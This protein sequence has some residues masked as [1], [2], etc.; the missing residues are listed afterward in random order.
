METYNFKH[1]AKWDAGK[2]YEVT[3]LVEADWGIPAMENKVTTIPF[4]FDLFS[5][6]PVKNSHGI[7]ITYPTAR[8]SLGSMR[9]QY[10]NKN[11]IMN[12][13]PI[14][15]DITA[16]HD[17]ILG[18]ILSARLVNGPEEAEVFIEKPAVCQVLAAIWVLS[19]HG[20]Q[21]VN[22]LRKAI[23]VGEKGEI[24]A[25]YEIMFNERG[26]IWRNK[27]YQHGYSTTDEDI[28]TLE[29]LNECVGYRSDGT[30]YVAH[31]YEGEYP[32]LL[33]GGADGFVLFH[34]A[35]IVDDGHEPADETTK[36][37]FSLLALQRATANYV[38]DTGLKNFLASY[39]QEIDMDAETLK[40]LFEGV[41]ANIV[42]AVN[43]HI[44]KI[45]GN[46]KKVDETAV[47]ALA[48]KVVADQAEALSE[49]FTA[50]VEAKMDEERPKIEAEIREK[51]EAEAK[52]LADVLTLA[53]KH[54]VEVKA[55]ADIKDEERA[56][57]RE[58]IEE[59]AK[60][61]ETAMEKTKAKI[62]DLPEKDKTPEKSK[63]AALPAGGGDGRDEGSGFKSPETIR[64]EIDNA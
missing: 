63:G 45:G 33:A 35:G 56:L 53:E 48:Q 10:V 17:T 24:A 27:L 28:A 57:A 60:S 6:W 2:A 32:T 59:F 5:T 22:K 44:E 31:S 40:A 21:L 12:G 47:M 51:Y 25:S 26:F 13:S 29:K 14:T 37:Q 19:E 58:E 15:A 1:T 61:P 7:A 50:A 55:K 20:E 49:K 30:I 4:A 62:L 38:A 52:A 42:K 43:E 16:E 39:N 9:H 11:H 41:E 36:G 64:E 23:A 46:D 34:G 8:R 3:N 54:E 18:T